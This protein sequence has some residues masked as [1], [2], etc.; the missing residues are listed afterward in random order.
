[1]SAHPYSYSSSLDA[2]DCVAP[3][4]VVVLSN[5]TSA[6]F[7]GMSGSVIISVAALTSNGLGEAAISYFRMPGAL[8][9]S[10]QQSITDPTGGFGASG[11]IAIGVIIIVIVV[12]VLLF[13]GLH[14]NQQGSLNSDLEFELN[15]MKLGI[16]ELTGKV[17]MKTWREMEREDG[18]G[19][20]VCVY[21]CLVLTFICFVLYC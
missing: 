16:E 3:N 2:L 7:A 20:W 11:L 4:C 1:M 17:S 21:L 12:G 6:I 10:T 5:V 15:Q 8:D 18:G 19:L 14:G 9:V 13:I